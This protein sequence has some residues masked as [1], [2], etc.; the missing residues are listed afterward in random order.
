MSHVPDVDLN[1]NDYFSSELATRD[2]ERLDC[3]DANHDT[4]GRAWSHLSPKSV[5]DF[6][7]DKKC[8]RIGWP[9]H[10]ALVRNCCR[11]IFY[12]GWVEPEAPCSGYSLDGETKNFIDG[13]QGPVEFT[14]S[15]RDATY[16]V[17][18]VHRPNHPSSPRLRIRRLAPLATERLAHAALANAVLLD[19]RHDVASAV[20][21][22][23]LG[24]AVRVRDGAAAALAR[25]EGVF[26]EGGGGGGGEGGGTGAGDEGEEGEEKGGEL[27]FGGWWISRCCWF[28]FSCV[29]RGFVGYDA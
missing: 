10:D 11:C 27:H 26:R 29:V 19:R 8:H 4:C 28:G 1:L 21:F 18:W 15:P 23:R 22:E 25:D 16:Y 9:L 5:Y 12:L 6:Q 3:P 24:D 2:D 13:I 14:G 20:P 7:T 17:C